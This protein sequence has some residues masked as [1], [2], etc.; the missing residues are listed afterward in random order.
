MTRCLWLLA[1]ELEDTRQLHAGR[2]YLREAGCCIML[3]LLR[4]VRR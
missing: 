2:D 1:Y 3:A 4:W